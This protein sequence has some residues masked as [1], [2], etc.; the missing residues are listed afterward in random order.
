[1]EG[2]DNPFDRFTA[3][4]KLALQLAEKEAKKAKSA[5]IGSHDLLLALMQIP[6]S[7]AFSIL[8]GAG[9][10]LESIRMVLDKVKSKDIEKRQEQ[11]GLSVQLN[12]TIEDALRA[13]HQYRHANV[14]TEHLLY[15]LVSDKDNAAAAIL[16]SMN[17]NANGLKK[18]IEEMFDQIKNFKKRQKSLEQ[19]ID[20]FLQGLQGA[21]VNLNK[22]QTNYEEGEN[23]G[24]EGGIP[25]PQQEP[26]ASKSVPNNVAKKVPSKTPALDYFTI[27][28]IEKA[29]NGEL[30]PIIGRDK[31]IARVIN[32][33]NRKNKN[34]PVLVGEPGVGKTAITEGLAQAIVQEKVPD[35]LLSKRILLLNMGSVVAGTKYRGE[36]EQRV[37]DIITEAGK[38]ENQVILFIDELHTVIGAGSAEGSLDA[39]NILKP[40]LSRGSL[41]VIGATTTDEYRKHIE[42]DKALE[43]RFQMV[44]VDEPTIDN[45]IKILSELRE[46]YEDYHNLAI[47]DEA[48][49]AAV[50]LSDR[51]IADR[52]LPDK[53][54]DV[55]DEA[56]AQK[57]A[58]SESNIGLIRD[59]Q[60]KIE[61]IEQKKQEA[62]S[63]QSYEKA[64][65]LKQKQEVLEREIDNVKMKKRPKDQR[66]P[67]TEEDVAAVVGRMTGIPVQKLIK[68]E[69]KKL[70]DLESVLQKYIVG[71]DDEIHQVAQAIRRSRTGIS[72]QNRPIGTFM[73]LG[74]TGVGKT[75]LVK[76]MAEEVF[77]NKE[78]LVKIDMS[79]FME[80]HSTSRLVG[81]SA[82]YVGYEDGGQLTE[83][84]RRK[85]YS[86]ILFDEVEKA[87]PDFFNLLLQ[88]FED[89]YLTDAKGKKVNFR[90]AI[91]VMTSNIGAD[92]LTN[93]ASEIGFDLSDSELKKAEKDYETKRGK[94]LERVKKHFRPEFLNRVDKI[95]VFHPLTQKSIKKIVKLKLNELQ[96]RIKEKNITLEYSNAVIDY[97]ARESYHP[98]Y[99]A[100]EVRRVVQSHIEDILSEKLLKQEIKEGDI[101]KIVRSDN[102]KKI[103]VIKGEK[104]KRVK[105]LTKKDAELVK[106]S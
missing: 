31:E 100:R 94:V 27:D 22:E 95:L 66:L 5:Y 24:E 88:V 43:R 73:F 70:L 7:L 17:I 87:H 8:T 62:V 56:A 51:Y 58:R 12:K 55:V 44:Q 76:K 82:G 21:L 84:V 63:N 6:K 40:A 83:A 101:A 52:F 30:D 41:Q 89:G 65:K 74:P 81:A 36:F 48:I 3:N 29:R 39:A 86:V 1:M 34:N 75:E 71:Q 45:A 9:I 11:G 18:K 68:S 23:Y 20:T 105:K 69:M 77:N 59:K 60:K 32:I 93:Q 103:D 53:A 102:G 72:D 99:G 26:Q 78:A 42:K 38:S 96:D 15:G 28:L 98:E 35:S 90:N 57:G 54:I 49:E 50:K 13:A 64:L 80:R 46:S 104:K 4:A 106:T 19:T 16:K 92:E 37:K 61:T 47:T 67:L 79:E 2:I 33:L 10:S 14:G 91:I 25:P 85:P 97:L